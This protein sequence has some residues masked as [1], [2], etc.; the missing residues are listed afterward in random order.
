V[1]RR[2]IQ[3]KIGASVVLVDSAE[4]TALQ[5]RAYLDSKQGRVVSRS[6]STGRCRIFVTDAAEQ[7]KK[8]ARL[9]IKKPLNIEF[10]DL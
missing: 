5:L 6:D 2:V 8:T 9:I 1:L 3:K 4:A 7:F 10:A